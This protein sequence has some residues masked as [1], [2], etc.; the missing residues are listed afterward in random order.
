MTSSEG[1]R[2]KA[3]H[4]EHTIVA[5][6]THCVMDRQHGMGMLV[7]NR[8]NYHHRLQHMRN[9]ILPSSLF[10]SSYLNFVFKIKGRVSS[11][12]RICTA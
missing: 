3:T 10:F 7:W 12:S 1:G 2:T 5:Q 8:L 9:I 4:C 11:P 6:M